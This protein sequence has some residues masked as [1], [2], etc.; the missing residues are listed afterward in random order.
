MCEVY[1]ENLRIVLDYI[2]EFIESVDGKSVVTADHGELLGDSKLQRYGHPEGV[3][4]PELRIVPWLSVESE[5]RRTV[6]E[7]E[8]IGVEEATKRS[9][10]E[11][12]TELGYIQ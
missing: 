2:E 3:Y 10:R 9:I 12:L 5:H 11:N 8:P 6:E 4:L 7:E 1:R